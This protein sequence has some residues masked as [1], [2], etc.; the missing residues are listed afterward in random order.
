MITSVKNETIKNWAKLHQKKYREQEQRF[1]VEGMHLVEEAIKSD[2][3]VERLIVQEGVTSSFDREEIPVTVVTNN[4]LSYL[5]Q[6]KSPQGILAI[7]KM[8]PFHPK[9]IDRILMLDAV[10]DPGNLGTMIRTADA[11]GFDQVILG[12]GTVDLYNDKV[13]RASQG[14]I[15]HLPIVKKNLIEEIERLQQQD[16]VICVSTLEQAEPI[17]TLD[18]ADKMALIV[19]NEGSGIAPSLLELADKRIHIPI[20]GQAESLNVSIA[21]AIMMYQFV[22]GK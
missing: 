20:Y 13:I 6:T 2:W 10:Q 14:S 3:K 1:I 7:V 22:L 12:E 8:N 5:A 21:A 19:G 15:F 16:V 18:L 9:V 4:V 11:A 17:Q